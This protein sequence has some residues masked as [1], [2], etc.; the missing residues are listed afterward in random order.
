ML[1]TIN[2]EKEGVV[3]FLWGKAAEK[4]AKVVSGDKHHKLTYG[5]P[6]PLAQAS[7]KFENCTNFSK[8]NLL[9]KKHGKD[10]IDWNI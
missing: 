2:R 4:I 6:S 8:C 1:K 7:M 3:F 9:L 5:H 10:P